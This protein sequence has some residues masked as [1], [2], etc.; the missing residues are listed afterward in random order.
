MLKGSNVGKRKSA[1]NTEYFLELKE[2]GTAIRNLIDRQAPHSVTKIIGWH[3]FLNVSVLAS[4]AIFRSIT[5]LSRDKTFPGETP[6]DP[7]LGLTTSPLVRSL[8]ELLFTIIFIKEKP[9]PRVKWFHRAGWKELRRMSNELNIRY[10]RDSAWENHLKELV[11]SVEKVRL[12]H[13]IPKRFAMDDTLIKRWPDGTKILKIGLKKRTHRF[14]EHISLLYSTLS[15]DHHLSGGGIIRVYAKLLI[16][17]DDDRRAPILKALKHRNALLAISILLAIYSEIN[18][19]CKF[20]R[21]TKLAYCWD[22]LVGHFEFANELH[23]LRYKAMLK[24]AMAHS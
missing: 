6:P 5:Y 10:E 15:Q 13:R 14:V 7:E 16:P 17:D 23:S 1:I 18:D 24:R 12:V 11:N 22:I 4:Q 21:G 3:E 2:V 19:I 9:G 8:L 20:N